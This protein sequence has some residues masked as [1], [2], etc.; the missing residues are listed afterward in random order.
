MHIAIL[1]FE[2]FNELDSFIALGVLS[3]VKR[4]DWQ[5]SIAS[6]T[7]HVRSMN[8]VSLESQASLQD[9][10]DADAVIVGSGKLTC[11]IVKTPPIMD[12]LRFDPSR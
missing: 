11:E 4:P 2:G 9:A 7:P 8:G 12:E 1:T 6:P 5:V 10:R 3:R